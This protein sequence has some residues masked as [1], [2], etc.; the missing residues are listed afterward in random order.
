MGGAALCKERVA[1][2]ETLVV[3]A[4][5]NETRARG[6]GSANKW[7][8]AGLSVPQGPKPPFNLESGL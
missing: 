6:M 7:R 8:M 4:I 1:D 5:Y 2:A 3:P